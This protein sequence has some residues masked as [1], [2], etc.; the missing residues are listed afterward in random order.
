MESL[1]VDETVCCKAVFPSLN[2]KLYNRVGYII[3]N[4]VVVLTA[5]ILGNLFDTFDQSMQGASF[6]LII[7]HLL[8]ILLSLTGTNV[9]LPLNRGFWLIK[10]L[11]AEGIYVLVY[12]FAG[13]GFYEGY[14]KY[15]K[16]ICLGFIIYLAIISVSFGHFLNVRLW[17]NVEVLREAGV[18]S[19]GWE[20]LLWALTII[21]YA[22][23]IAFY[24]DIF[25]TT[26]NNMKYSSF[27][28]S[29]IGCVGSIILSIM[30]IS[31]ICE[32]KKL[33]NSAYVSAFIA[34][35]FWSGTFVNDKKYLSDTRDFLDIIFGITFVLAAILFLALTSKRLKIEREDDKALALNPFLEQ[36]DGELDVC[37]QLVKDGSGGETK[38]YMVT[39]SFFL[40]QGFLFF[41]SLYYSM[42]FTNW[43][44][45]GAR[46]YNKGFGYFSKFITAF[47]CGLLY[48]WVIIAPRVCP[49]RTFDF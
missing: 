29:F 13:K 2:P 41:L 27:M 37:T 45:Y 6:S 44:T 34:Y 12:M 18:S 47:A 4:A 38:V 10:I 39:R 30:S 36:D 25:E 48:L 7:F 32:R 23:A 16:Y 8:I 9:A 49:D 26:I 28:F 21:F 31:P 15:S 33:L 1:C 42:L 19:A 22:A 43:L 46:D 24:I 20:G 3:V 5:I 17:S 14:T 40:F 35:L 11:V